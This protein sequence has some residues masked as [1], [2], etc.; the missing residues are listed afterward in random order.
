[1]RGFLEET[2][3]EN[4]KEKHNFIIATNGLELHDG[5]MAAKQLFNS[6]NKVTAVVSG[7]Y[8]L[9]R[10]ILRA[11]T[12]LG[13]NVPKELSIVSYDNIPQ[14]KDLQIHLTTVGVPTTRIA[15]EIAKY[16][17][18]MIETKEPI[19]SVVLEPEINIKESTR[20]L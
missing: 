10:G 2:G 4:T 1:M 19:N 14:S 3:I 8:D 12:E 6:N 9:T 18:K 15:N 17:L 7:S 11:A 13:I 16:V 20:Q 5:Y